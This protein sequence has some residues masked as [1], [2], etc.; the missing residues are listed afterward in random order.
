[1][2]FCETQLQGD[3]VGFLKGIIKSF[4]SAFIIR[5]AMRFMDKKRR[6]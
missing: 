3:T 2:T 5:E 6:R 1:V 4:V